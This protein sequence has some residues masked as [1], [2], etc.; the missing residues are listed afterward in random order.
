VLLRRGERLRGY[1]AATLLSV[2]AALAI[3]P[4]TSALRGL[5][6]RF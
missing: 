6:D 1:V 3:E 4:V 2:V 5:A